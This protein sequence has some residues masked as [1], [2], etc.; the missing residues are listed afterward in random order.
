[1]TASSAAVDVRPIGHENTAF[2]VL[3]AIG[4]SHLLNDMIQSLIPAIYP[5]LKTSFFLSFTQIGLITLTFQITASSA[6][7]GGRTLHGSPP[8]TL[9]IGRRHGMH[10]GRADHS[11]LCAELWHSA[12]CSRHGGHGLVRL[13]S[14]IIPG[15][16]DGVRRPLRTGAVDFSGG[17]KCR[18]RNGSAAGGLDR[19]SAWQ[20]QHCMVLAG[21]AAGHARAVA[22]R[23]LV[24]ASAV[25]GEAAV[26]FAALPGSASRRVR[27]Q[28]R[29]RSC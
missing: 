6:P 9:F 14:G 28:N 2:K 21:R 10:P 12:D 1:M 5:L 23:R 27:L 4:F 22:G 7:A 11:G 13:P 29:W 20:E 25:A 26:S 16:A 3:G 8:E 17:R 24:Q 19:H 18:Q 15:C